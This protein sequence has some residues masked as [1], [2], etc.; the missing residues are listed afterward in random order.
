V[1][2][3]DGSEGDPR[4][5][6]TTIG[7][8]VVSAALDDDIANAQGHLGVVE[9]ER[10]PALQHNAGVDRRGPVHR[11]LAPGGV[12]RLDCGQRCGAPVFQISWK[13]HQGHRGRS[14]QAWLYASPGQVTGS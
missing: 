12:D 13:R 8:G 6:V 5:R 3:P 7:P 11:E 1:T 9:N 10:A 14:C 2:V 4:D